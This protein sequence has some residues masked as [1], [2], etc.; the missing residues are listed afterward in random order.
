MPGRTGNRSLDIITESEWEATTRATRGGKDH[1]ATR[2][3]RRSQV[4]VSTALF[5][6]QALERISSPE[7]L[8]RVV[9]AARPLQWVALI[10]LLV[11]V[12]ATVAWAAI[13]TVPTTFAAQ[14]FYTT[15][16]GL[17]PATT[18]VAGILTRL[19]VTVVGAQVSAG[20]VL[21]TVTTP[22]P[23]DTAG[24]PPIYNVVAP[25]NG[26]VVDVYHLSGTYQDVN[27]DVALIQPTGRPLVVYSFVPTEKASG[28][29]RGVPAQVT[30][31]AGVGAALGYA[32]GVVDSV[33]QYPVDPAIV[34]DLTESTSI[35]DAVRAQ[36]PSKEV[37]VTLTPSRTPSGLAWAR[38]QGPPGRLP[39]GL[40][41]DVQFVL[42]SHHPISNVI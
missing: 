14:G 40:P 24:T 3:L 4:A 5:R 13:A 7:Q 35:A 10:A 18:P 37:V 32:K 29:R 16:G 11:V 26:V 33:S 25:Q 17:H 31:G 12:A 20:Q 2:R 42:G 27:Q 21:A 19:P 15:V 34:Q 36:G 28:L 6:R 39:P 38:G 1:G 22:V 9:R 23:R 41:I 30:F 8:D